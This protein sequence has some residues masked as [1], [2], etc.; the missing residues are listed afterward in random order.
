MIMGKYQCVNC[1]DCLEHAI[2][3]HKLPQSTSEKSGRDLPAF[4]ALFFETFSQFK[5]RAFHLTGESYAVQKFSN[6]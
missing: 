4:V 6:A 3:D 5:D 1:R 2:V